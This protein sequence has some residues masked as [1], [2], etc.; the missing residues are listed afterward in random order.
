LKARFSARGL[1]LSKT[2][3]SL[4]SRRFNSS[5]VKPSCKAANHRA[6]H[7]YPSNK[8]TSQMVLSTNGSPEVLVESLRVSPV[9]GGNLAW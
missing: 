1:D 6:L 5:C 4:T 7:T 2:A 3:F 9:R 8:R